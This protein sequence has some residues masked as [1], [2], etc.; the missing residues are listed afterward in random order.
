MG[1]RFARQLAVF[2]QAGEEVGVVLGGGV[3]F[4]VA[5]DVLGDVEAELP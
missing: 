1:R 5:V 3:E 4:A 2:Q